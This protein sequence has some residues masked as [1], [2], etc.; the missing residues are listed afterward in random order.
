VSRPA[1]QR[2][3]IL[4]LDSATYAFQVRSA[5]SRPDDTPLMVELDDEPQSVEVDPSVDLTATAETA[6]DDEGDADED[7]GLSDAEYELANSRF[8]SLPG[9]TAW[10][11]LAALVATMAW[12]VWSNGVHGAPDLKPVAKDRQDAE[13]YRSVVE[14]V[15]SGQ[16]YY[17]A[18]GAELRARGYPRR[19]MF[20]WRQPTYAL[21]LAHLP[22]SFP[23]P[24]LG[25]LMAATLLLTLRWLGEAWGPRPATAV[26]ALHAGALFFTLDLYVF[27]EAWAGSLI[28]LALTLY[29]FGRWRLGVVTLLAALAFREFA[30]L[31]CAVALLLAMYERRWPE[32]RLWTAGLVLYSLLMVLHALAVQRHLVAGDF[33]DVPRSWIAFGGPQFLTAT[34]RFS[35]VFYY[36]PPP[37]TA[38]LLPLALVGYAG[39]RDPGADRMGLSLLGFLCVFSVIG[40]PFDLYWGFV[41]LPL[42]SVGIVRAPWSLRDLVLA[43]ARPRPPSLSAAAAV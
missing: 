25:L 28:I 2:Q 12:F 22:R 42:L 36:L 35:L 20:N 14:R 30:L 13:L 18:A 40:Q 6:N 10:A 5:R 38:L 29:A 1:P 9:R 23:S 11:I 41:F 37:V 16:P 17:E 7:E 4:S 34:S 8:R 3:P 15:R 24:L 19:P 32:V 21:L 33:L 26:I 39:W 31:P 27:Q 43:I